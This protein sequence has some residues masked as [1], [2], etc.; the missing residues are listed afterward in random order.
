MIQLQVLNRVLSNHDA[1]ILL[2]NNLNQEFF[3]DY[4]SEYNFIQ[5]HLRKYGTVP[6]EVTFLAKFPDFDVINVTETDSYL[7][8]ALFEDRN[9]RMLARV[10]NRVREL[11]NAGKTD[12]AMKTYMA[13]S[14]DVVKA[15]HLDC[16]DILK[17][18][19]RYD[20]YVERTED[21]NK[22]Y[23]KTGIKELDDVIGGWDRKE[24]LATIAARTNVG[25][26]WVL[27]KVAIAA[28][29][30]GL[31]VGIYSGEMTENKVGYRI[32]TLISHISNG[33]L[34]HGDSSIEND[35][36]RY[37]EGLK[38]KI[39]G[40]IKVLTPAMIGCT[41]GV[42]ALR[43]FI[44][45]EK[46]D[47]L[48]IDQH[49]LLEDDRGARDPVQKAADISKDLKT[50]QVLKQIPIIAV[51]QLNRTAVNS[52]TGLDPSHIAQ[53]DRI[54]Q[55]STIIIGLEKKEN[56]MTLTLLKSRDSLVGARL[57]YALDLDKGMFIFI[58]NEDDATNGQGCEELKKQ[59]EAVESTGTDVF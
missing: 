26:S 37:L 28:A 49:S 39:P 40:S 15:T 31:N 18:T 54:A 1:S 10:F 4:I 9:K 35:Y 16:V 32:D 3:S 6:D 48:C 55:D 8:D 23:V 52:E 45:K 34:I 47:M 21:Y 13:A 24:E 7:V 42:T 20:A 41:P 57:K 59:F 50:L 43:A 5:E 46:L 11:L 17:D 27:L 36:K 12:E 51:S 29:Q 33:K 25:K 19:S 53:S 58:P 22:Y 56:V 44:E 2:T 14:N 30:Q 38:D